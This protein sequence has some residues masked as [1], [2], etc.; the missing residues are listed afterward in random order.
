MPKCN[1]K[2]SPD[3][4]LHYDLIAIAVGATWALSRLLG[5]IETTLGKYVEKNEAEHKAINAQ[6]IDLK[7][8]RKGR[9]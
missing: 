9:R 5:K 7:K 1:A 6:I 3:M 8:V 2:G 4:D